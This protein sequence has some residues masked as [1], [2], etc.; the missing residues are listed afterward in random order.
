MTDQ[1]C[2]VCGCTDDRACVT[3]FGPC[4]WIAKDLC[5][6]CSPL[7]PVMDAIEKDLPPEA[8]QEFGP[9]ERVC[10]EQSMLLCGMEEYPALVG[11]P[12]GERCSGEMICEKCGQE[13]FVHPMDWR[14]IGYGNV[15]FLNVLCDGRRVKL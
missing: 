5:S 8:A 14:V 6:A 15:P 12:S 2:R 11:D 9:I 3:E 7:K 1:K 4:H 13:Y 10:L